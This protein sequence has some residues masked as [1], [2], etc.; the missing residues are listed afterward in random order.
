MSLKKKYLKT[1][2]VCKVTFKIPK[3]A[4][5]GAREINI[6]GDFNSWNAAASPMKSL[7]NGGFTLTL[8]L[9][10]DKEY[11]FRYLFDN[12]CWEN[13][14]AADK[15]MPSSMGNCDNSVVIL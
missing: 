12:I 5:K 10:K 11:Q 3:E 1:R 9:N 7:K 15:Y 4:A 14:W 2:P 6:V 13:D 8:D